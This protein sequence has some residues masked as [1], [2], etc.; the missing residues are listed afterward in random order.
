[1]DAVIYR[2]IKSRLELS[3]IVFG[4]CRIE[5]AAEQYVSVPAS[6]LIVAE[7]DCYSNGDDDV[8]L[9]NSGSSTRL[10]YQLPGDYY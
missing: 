6:R 9:S 4:L 2:P 1:M 8:F 7:A 5:T 10:C 3:P